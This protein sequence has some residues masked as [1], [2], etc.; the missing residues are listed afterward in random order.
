[1]AEKIFHTR[2][3]HKHDIESNWNSID[4]IPKQGEIIIYDADN[5]YTYERLKIGD[6]ATS[7]NSLPFVNDD[8]QNLINTLVGDVSVSEQISNAIE[9]K[10]EKDL[11][12]TYQNGSKYYATHDV[13][14]IKEAADNG[15]TVKFLK[16]GEFL[17]LL[18]ATKD[19]ATFY[20]VYINMNNKLQ[21]KIVALSSNSIM[22][23]QDD[24]YDYATKSYVD[25]KVAI[26]TNSTIDEICGMD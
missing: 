9:N 8:V 19:F 21:Q 22:L 5:N 25:N 26:I 14:E 1:M 4:F 15:R 18:E 24:T 2:I 6:G 17:D 16:D 20:I 12:V 10:K 3:V 23:E 13:S 11:I 7:I